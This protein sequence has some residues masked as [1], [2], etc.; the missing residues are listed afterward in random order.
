MSQTRP[1]LLVSIVVHPHPFVSSSSSTL[2]MAFVWP[3]ETRKLATVSADSYR[4]TDFRS[5]AQPRPPSRTLHKW[6]SRN[7]KGCQCSHNQDRL[8][9]RL[10]SWPFSA[11]ESSVR[12]ISGRL[13]PFASVACL[14]SP[15]DPPP[16]PSLHAAQ[17]KWG[18]FGLLTRE[19][20]Q[21][22]YL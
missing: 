14:S 17:P 18:E 19:G 10:S 4:A 9:N 2:S 16:R 8:P 6:A 11:T 21:I 22:T 13:Q 12:S 20:W 1:S 15:N 7:R 3:S 5:R